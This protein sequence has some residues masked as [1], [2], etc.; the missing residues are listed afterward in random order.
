MAKQSAPEKDLEGLHLGRFAISVLKLSSKNQLVRQGLCC[1]S[2]D[3]RLV[4]GIDTDGSLEIG[5]FRRAP[6]NPLS[7]PSSVFGG[8]GRPAGNRGWGFRL[9]KGRIFSCADGSMNLLTHLVD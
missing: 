3:S 9:K 2:K 1:T 4:A 6:V 8:I 5:V 7:G